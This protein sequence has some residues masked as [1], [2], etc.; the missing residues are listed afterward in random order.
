MGR[1]GAARVAERHDAAAEVAKLAGYIRE[2]VAGAGA[3]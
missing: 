1:A 3:V 2:S